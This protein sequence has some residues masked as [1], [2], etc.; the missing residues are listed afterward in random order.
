MIG[1]QS[2]AH[3]HSMDNPRALTDIGQMPTLSMGA[4]GKEHSWHF[5]DADLKPA[6][7]THTPRLSTDDLFTLRRAA[8]QGVRVACLPALVVT[9]DL[10]GGALVRLLPSLS[11]DQ[12]RCTRRVPIQAW[13]GTRGSLAARLPVGRLRGKSVARQQRPRLAHAS[14]TQPAT[15]ERKQRTS[16]ND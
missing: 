5:V 7:L 10:S 13:D 1:S 11:S 3:C 15:S 14:S 2:R 8:I 16:V 6:A 9:D 12:W 4:V